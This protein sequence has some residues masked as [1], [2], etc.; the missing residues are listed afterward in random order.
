MAKEEIKS[1][2]EVAEKEVKTSEIS[3]RKEKKE[4]KVK[5]EFTL[6]KLYKPGSTV[7]LEE[8]KI[9]ESLISNKFI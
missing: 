4:Y 7:L 1:Y 3:T 6:D 2:P 8:G 9:K 5:K